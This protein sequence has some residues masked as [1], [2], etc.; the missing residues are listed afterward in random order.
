MKKLKIVLLSVLAL[1]FTLTSCG[2][3]D[4]T[5]NNNTSG[6]LEGKWIMDKEGEII[7]GHE[8]LSGYPHQDDCEKDYLE[9]TE[10]SFKE[11]FYDTECS[12]WT[13]DR[14]YTRNG[15]T[16]T[17]NEGEGEEETVYTIKTLTGS[18]LKVE[19]TQTI[20]GETITW[21]DTFKRG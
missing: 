9:I 13:D 11:V 18:D 2:D 17:V 6:T 16:V 21:V 7:N 1:G 15:N 3:D 12:A 4:S 20:E 19:Y 10:T 5:S 14:T 8:E